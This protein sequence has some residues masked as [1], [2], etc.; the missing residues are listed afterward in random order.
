M[1]HELLLYADW[2]SYRV[3]PHPVRVSK[4]VGAD[5]P[6]ARF[7]ASSIK[8]TPES[9]VRVGQFAELQR[10]SENPIAARWK[11]SVLLPHFQAF[12]KLVRDSQRLARLVGFYIVHV[13]LYDATLYA[14]QSVEPIDIRPS[15][16]QTR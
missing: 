9:S 2:S 10:T 12:K 6:D 8:L 13:L 5:V 1:A 4:R 7:F 14:K 16:R 15:Q 3:N 11:L